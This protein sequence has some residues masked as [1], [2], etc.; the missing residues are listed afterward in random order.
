MKLSDDAMQRAMTDLK[1][2]QQLLHFM[3]RLY[4]YPFS[5]QK[6]IFTRKP[7]AEACTDYITWTKR[8]GRTVKMGTGIPLLKENGNV[9]YVYDVADTIAQNGQVI[10][11]WKVTDSE[12]EEVLQS[13]SIMTNGE[14]MDVALQRWILGRIEDAAIIYEAQHGATTVMPAA[15]ECAYFIAARRC[16]LNPPLP[17]AVPDISSIQKFVIFGDLINRLVK[18]RLLMWK[19]L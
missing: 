11:F 12:K 19:R 13:L 7:T 10:A 6:F 5:D 1:S 2:F 8:L 3:S 14:T 18:M 4:K 15:I 9:D 17:Q 16:G